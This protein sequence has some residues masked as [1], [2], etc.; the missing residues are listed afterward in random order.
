LMS[1]LEPKIIY[2]G[3]T[4]WLGFFLDVGNNYYPNDKAFI[5]NSKGDSLTYLTAFF[6]SS[7]F[8]C[9]YIDEFPTQ[10]EDRRELRKIFFEKLVVRKPTSEQRRSFDMLVPL[11]Q[12]ARQG[13]DDGV[14]QFF[15]D[16]IDACVLECYFPDH[17]GERDLLFLDG[18]TPYVAAYES[19]ADASKQHDFL[20]HVH[21]SLN[22]PDAKIRNRLLRLTADSPTLLGVIKEEGRV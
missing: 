2:P 5:I 20:I 21:R 9:A 13:G 18:L 4:K 3:I 8:R 14:A 7:L 11:V 6:N 1:F 19:N 22:A 15:E 12:L 16:L 17:M 10:G